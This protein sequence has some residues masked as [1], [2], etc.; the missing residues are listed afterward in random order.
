MP[1]AISEPMGCYCLG[2]EWNRGDKVGDAYDPKTGH[3]IEFKAS[4]NMEDLSSFGPDTK[5]DNLY[6][7][8]FD[9]ENDILR[10]Y[11]LN[12]T[13]EQLKAYPTAKNETFGDKQK[14]GK[15]PHISLYKLFVKDKNLKPAIVFDIRR[16]SII[17]DNR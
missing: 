8:Q 14:A 5:F 11:D 4:S 1:D 9:T 16:A 13:S 7:L 15:R 3:K 2:F 6:F 17:E 12:I 10:I